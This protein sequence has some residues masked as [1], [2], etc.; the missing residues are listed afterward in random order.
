MGYNIFINTNILFAFINCKE[1]ELKVKTMEISQ[2][3]L[4]TVNV[5]WITKEE[6]LEIQG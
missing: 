3:L 4:Y 2:I 6:F 1:D 5:V